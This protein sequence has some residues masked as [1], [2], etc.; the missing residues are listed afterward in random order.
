LAGNNH[1]EDRMRVLIVTAGAMTVA[2]AAAAAMALHSPPS[3]PAHAV[4]TVAHAS[5]PSDATPGLVWR[6]GSATLTLTGRPCP[7]EDL[8]RSLVGEGVGEPRAY[9]VS[10][11]T[12]R[13][14]GCW[15]KDVGGDVVT[16][17]PGR[18]VGSIPIEWFQRA[19]GS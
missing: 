18:E 1:R 13:Y 11:G 15:T 14:I 2:A 12:R 19:S 6:S 10:Q 4:R 3:R 16:A 17:E 9:E 7:N 8:S 5:A